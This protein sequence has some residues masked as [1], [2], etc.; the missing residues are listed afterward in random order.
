M[1]SADVVDQTVRDLGGGSA[2]VRLASALALAKSKDPRAVIALADALGK[3]DDPAVRRVCALA[4][5]KMIDA[6][7]PGDALALAFDALDR[8][9]ARDEDARVRQSSAQVASALATY[10]KSATHPG[11]SDKPDVFVKIDPVTDA[12]SRT[13][14]DASE[15]L[16]IVL[17]KRVHA[18]GYAT[19]W[20]GGAPSSADL[21]SARTRAF[22]VAS[23]VKRVDIARVGHQT[24]IACTLQIRIAPWSGSDGGE[25]WEANK[26]ANASGSATAMTGT[27]QRAIE[28]GVRDCL[29]AVAEDLTTRQLLPFLQQLLVASN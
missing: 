20:P 24:R 4:L 26:S 17:Q 10:R 13:P 28:G 3:D 14:S 15:R 5:E 12:S 1:A 7:T 19:A 11:K 2:K 9:A 27:S 6:H 21:A 29:E 8:A 16:R 25:K 22:V 23:T 18:K